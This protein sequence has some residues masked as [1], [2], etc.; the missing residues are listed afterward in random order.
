MEEYYTPLRLPINEFF[1]TVKDQLWVKRLRPIH[2]NPASPEWKSVIP[3]TTV[4]DTKSS[5][6]RASVDTWKSLF[7]K[8]FS[9]KKYILTPG[10]PPMQESQALRHLFNRN[11]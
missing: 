9:K 2:Y 1:N 11:I 3:S 8:T 7:A 4:K 10:Q 6:A 5:T